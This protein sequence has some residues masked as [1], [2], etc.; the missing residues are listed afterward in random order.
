[1]RLGYLENQLKDLENAI[2]ID[3]VS[4]CDVKNLIDLYKNIY[5]LNRA[6]VHKECVVIDCKEAGYWKY[7]AP[8][9][10]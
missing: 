10:M 7:F 8:Y 5:R 3:D 1:M 4:E 2:R 6:S 9:F